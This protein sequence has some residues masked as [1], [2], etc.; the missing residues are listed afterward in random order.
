MG[1]IRFLL[2]LSVVVFHSNQ[3]FF[4][5]DFVGGILAV[6]MFYIISGFY[7]S[8]ILNEKYINQNNSYYLF[9]SN[10]FL[11]LFPLY[12]LILIAAIIVNLVIY[13]Y[14]D[15]SVV[16][17]DNY[18]NYWNQFSFSTNF[19]LIGANLLV[20]GQDIA[21]FLGFDLQ[22][23]GLYFTSDF[24]NTNPR[25]ANF[26][27]LGQAWTISLELMFYLIAP[28]IL[29]RKKRI[30]LLLIVLS[31][32][33]RIVIYY[34]FHLKNDPWTY[35]FFPNELF[36]FLIGFFCYKGY[37]Y[38]ESYKIPSNLLL[39]S[40][41]ILVLFTLFYGNIFKFISN[42]TIQSLLHAVYFGLFV[43]LLPLIF[44][45][46][47]KNKLDS[48]IG[49]LSYPLYLC[50]GIFIEATFGVNYNVYVIVILSVVF[51][52]LLNKL[53]SSRIENYRQRRLETT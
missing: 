15:K 49:D 11:R 33:L 44:T 50:H 3:S 5:A 18:K 51:S 17:F 24:V 13:F 27:I 52:F 1:I 31:F 12:Y 38:L 32:A 23:G 8:L 7:M 35:R 2:A 25:V 16:V 45:Y 21:L 43:I 10:R 30:I 4:G 36:Y 6:Q 9:I 20:F 22:N 46:T 19:Y 48:T 34:V 37:K 29:R 47:K 53:V 26:M 39:T 14:Y 41:L 42:P 40:L 28:F